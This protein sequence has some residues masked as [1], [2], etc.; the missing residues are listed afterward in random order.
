M[1]DRLA[2]DFIQDRYYSFKEAGGLWMPYSIF[3]PRNY[4][5]SKKWPLIVMLHGL[6]ITAVQQIRFEGVAELAE[7]YGYIVVC[8]TGYSVRSFWGMP[9]VCSPASGV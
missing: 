6:N 4:D 1:K 9:N 3:V 2:S 7:K 8:P 5:E